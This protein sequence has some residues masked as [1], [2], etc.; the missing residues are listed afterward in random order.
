MKKLLFTLLFTLSVQTISAQVSFTGNPEYGRMQNFVYDKTVEGKIYATTNVDKH[1]LV[2]SDNGVTWNVLYTLPY[3]LQAPSIKEMRLV[4]NGTALSFIEDFGPSNQSKI[5]ILNLNSLNII[6][7][8]NLPQG[9]ID[10]IGGYSVFD[11]G[12]MNTVLMIVQDSSSGFSSYNRK[13]YRTTNGGTTWSN[14]Y[15]S[16]QHILSDA[17]T[18]PQN[19]QILYIAKGLGPQSSVQGGFLK[20]M[21]AGATWTETL[22]NII[23]ESIAVDPQNPNT[24]YTGTAHFVQGAMPNMHPAVYKSTDGALTWTEQTGI[25]WSSTDPLATIRKIKLVIDPNNTNHVLALGV[26]KIA[27]TTNG[28][29][30]WTT[31]FHNGLADGTSYF[32][33]SGATFNPTN[34][35]QVLIANE[36][37]PKISTDGGIT[38][39]TILNPFFTNMGTVYTLKDNNVDKLV[40]GVQWGYTVKNL[41]N[42]QETPTTVLPLGTFPYGQEMAPFFINKNIAGRTYIFDG[43][44]FP[45]VIKMSNDYGATTN[46]LL[47]TYDNTLTAAE[48][49]PSNSNIAWLATYNGGTP[50]TKVDFSTMSNPVTTDL[51]FPTYPYD[52]GISGI[53][54]NQSNSN[55]AMVTIG[56]SIYKTTNG[57]SSWVETTVQGLNL[58]D[59]IISFSQ[60]PLNVNQYTLATTNGIYTSTDSGNTWTKIYN[61][62]ISKVEHST[63]QNGQIVALAKTTNNTPSKVIY[64]NDFGTTW[65]E[66]NASNYFNTVIQDGAVRFVSPTIAE[67]YL[68][69]YSLGVLKDVINFSSLGTSD[70]AITKDDISIYPNPA[71]DV[72]HIKF[73]NNTAKFKA[74]IYS[75]AGQLVLT[76]ENKTSIDISDLTKGVYLLKIDQGNAPTIVKKVIKK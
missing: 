2:S 74:T 58:P 43:T 23:L 33:P 3:P 61:G 55:I 22:N 17:K 8:F 15:D 56:N 40:Y 12:T 44:A 36:R 71:Q 54:I 59:Y 68:T 14:I 35:N 11:D 45:R 26:H 39:T 37:F 31:T 6:K 32:Y 29:S 65:Q 66:R 72:I 70:P 42:N 41:E 64:S 30:A 13:L 9:E 4:N 50:L 20:S 10:A 49:D 69:T 34:T 47:E 76:A 19:P 18:D 53:K 73:A 1:I 24:I 27:V 67:V 51:N 48:T 7:Q 16:G 63:I 75:T 57:G 60:N 21:D 25:D 46:T 62:I 38:L 5:S 28:G 52:Y